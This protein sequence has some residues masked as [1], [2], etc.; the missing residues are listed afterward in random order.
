MI[1]LSETSGYVPLTTRMTSN[2][3]NMN[4]NTAVRYY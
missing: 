1:C 2:V 4:K 3:K